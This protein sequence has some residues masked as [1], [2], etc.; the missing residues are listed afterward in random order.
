[1][2][3]IICSFVFLSGIC[4][5]G[6]RGTHYA[7]SDIESLRKSY[8]RSID[9]K[10]FERFRSCFEPNVRDDTRLR[11]LFDLE[12][13]EHQFLKRLQ[14]QT[15]KNGA[16][17]IVKLDY[18]GHLVFPVRWVYEK[19][20]S[21]PVL[22]NEDAIEVQLVSGQHYI[23][24]GEVVFVNDY[25]FYSQRPVLVDTSGNFFFYSEGW[26]LSSINETNLGSMEDG[27]E[28]YLEAARL[29]PDMEAAKRRLDLGL[30]PLENWRPIDGDEHVRSFL[31]R[32]SK[33]LKDAERFKSL[34]GTEEQ[35]R[36]RSI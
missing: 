11:V 8:F 10:D 36:F 6:N 25:G 1:M 20:F 27:V 32:T 2:V 35:L 30:I 15:E 29:L 5:C 19:S 24:G 7:V 33:R 22:N 14:A 28:T 21:L 17:E 31:E 9:E 34:S 16:L 23:F 13:A 12:V 4:G 26:D 18:S 3:C